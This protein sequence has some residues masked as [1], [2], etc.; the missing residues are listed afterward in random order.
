MSWMHRL[1]IVVAAGAA[2]LLAPS[3]A[4]AQGWPSQ[5]VRIMVGFAAGSTPD[6]I[7]RITADVLT[8][9]LGQPV[10]VES[11]PGAGGNVG[12]D[13]VAKAAPDGHTLGVSIAGALIVN[14]MVSNTPYDTARDIAFVTMLATQPSTLIVSPK[15]G[16]AS[17]ADLVAL[18][19]KEPGKHN[20]AS[21][22][23][24][25]ISHLAMELMKLHT[26]T[27][28]VHVPFKASPEAVLAVTSNNAQM[29]VLPFGA[30]KGLAEAGELR[31]LAVTTS[32][33][34]PEAP[35]VPTFADAGFPE[36]EADAWNALFVPART[37]APVIDRLHRE[38]RTGFGKPEMLARLQKIS[39]AP[40]VGTPTEAGAAIAAETARWSKVVDKLGLRR[41]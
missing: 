30:V 31:M 11:K 9:A 8:Q 40:I 22:G 21:I 4:G 33:R 16:P 29:A 38:I 28:V 1:A 14:P 32:R 37:P 19:R 26:G 15:L 3:G 23:V 10:V 34:W 2:V 20:Y 24:G 5:P 17:V 36:V 18:L 39:F 41:K 13:A 6:L 7:A 12:V 35:N 25:S 27:D